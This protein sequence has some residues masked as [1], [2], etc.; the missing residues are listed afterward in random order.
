[1]EKI[2]KSIN[3]EIPPLKLYINDLIDIFKIFKDNFKSF[4]IKT[5]EYLINSIDELETYHK[6]II[7]ELNFESSDPFIHLNLHRSGASIY[8][9]NDDAFS[10]GIA[11]KLYNI[12]KKNLNKLRFFSNNWIQIPLQLLFLIFLTL[13]LKFKKIIFVLITIFIILFII[14]WIIWSVRFS[15]RNHTIIYLYKKNEDNF[16]KRNFDKLLLRLI[17]LILGSLL[18]I[19]VQII[20]KKIL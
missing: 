4:K 17:T 15:M 1:M 18:T 20:L 5:D 11:Y 6:K 19:I 2:K 7:N 16:F 14:F 8:S 9:S 12:L 3:I 13:S 10:S